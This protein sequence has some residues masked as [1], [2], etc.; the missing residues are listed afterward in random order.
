MWA[1]GKHSKSRTGRPKQ[2][3]RHTVT[4][5]LTKIRKRWGGDELI[6]NNGVWSS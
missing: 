1:K 5:E 6:T 2:S 3:W 4:K